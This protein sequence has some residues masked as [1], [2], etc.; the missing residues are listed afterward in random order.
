[1][2]FMYWSGFV[3]TQALKQNYTIHLHNDYI[4]VVEIPM[5]LGDKQFHSFVAHD[6][7]L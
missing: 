7:L 4:Y 6:L 2:C 5:S 1:M 3:A